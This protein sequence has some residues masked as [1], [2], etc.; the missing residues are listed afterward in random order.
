MV[1]PTCSQKTENDKTELTLSDVMKSLST[2]SDDINEFKSETKA[3][4]YNSH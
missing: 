3:N 2:I 1:P 4:F